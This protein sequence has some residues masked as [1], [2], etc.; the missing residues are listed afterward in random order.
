MAA[1]SPYRCAR[2]YLTTAAGSIRNSGKAQL[3]SSRVE[4][5]ITIQILTN[6]QQLELSVVLGHKKTLKVDVQLLGFSP[7]LGAGILQH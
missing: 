2:N 4:T 3:V 1:K 6:N 7:L 5:T